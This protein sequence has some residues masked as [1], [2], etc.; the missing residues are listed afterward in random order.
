MTS[1]TKQK[2]LFLCKLLG[3]TF[4]PYLQLLLWHELGYLLGEDVV[5]YPILQKCVE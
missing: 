3:F 1:Q 2:L 5:M 4:K